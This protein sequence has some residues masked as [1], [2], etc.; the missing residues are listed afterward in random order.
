MTCIPCASQRATCVSTAVAVY[1]AAVSTPGAREI[2]HRA[3][4]AG[5]FQDVHAS[6]GPVDDVAV[7]KRM[8]TDPVVVLS[9]LWPLTPIMVLDDF[10]QSGCAHTTANAHGYYHVLDSTALSFQ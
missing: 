3:H 2:D 5:E 4:L 1:S 9:S 8:C 10:K 7:R 6:I